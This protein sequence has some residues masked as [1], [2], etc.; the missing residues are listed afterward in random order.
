MISNLNLK[1]KIVLLIG[2]GLILIIIAIAYLFLFQEQ[3]TVIDLNQ[4][5]EV[6]ENAISIEANE[7]NTQEELNEQL[8]ENLVEESLEGRL[9]VHIT[10]EVNETGILVL[11]EGSR[12]VDAIKAAGGETKE[13]DLN[14]VN[15][16][17]LLEDGQK[18]YIPNKK[19]KE[20]NKQNVYITSESGN[21]VIIEE[22]TK[23]KGVKP[24]VNINEA[25]QN[26]LETLPGI[27]PSI[28]SRIIKYR[29]EKGNFQKIED[30]QNVKGIG[31]A[32]FG[33]IKEYVT[34]R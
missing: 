21:N 19:D 9:V 2:G 6:E 34:V 12:I 4:I 23:G 31:D 18:I 5:I 20:Q 30:L 1:Q 13:A 28:A 17:Y 29:E 14:E 25:T 15:L 27:G 7:V 8:S 16:A 32:K 3:E 24:K 26:E 11:E 22:N 10:G 33:N